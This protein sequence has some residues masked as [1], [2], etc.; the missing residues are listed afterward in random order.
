[1]FNLKYLALPSNVAQVLLGIYDKL[2]G[3]D[4]FYALADDKINYL[5]SDDMGISWK[6]VPVSEYLKM[7]FLKS[8]YEAFDFTPLDT[9]VQS[10][11]STAGP[12][13]C[14]YCFFLIYFKKYGNFYYNF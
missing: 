5:R 14:K 1:M 13:T 4:F 2:T 10:F 7:Q 8:D 11:S 12:W 6:Y 9:T 3:E